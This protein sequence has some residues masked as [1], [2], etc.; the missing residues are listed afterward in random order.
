MLIGIIHL[1][2]PQ[3]YR[4]LFVPY[5]RIRHYDVGYHRTDK[6]GR[7]AAL[8][9]SAYGWH[10]HS[11]RL[12]PCMTEGLLWSSGR[13]LYA[14]NSTL[15]V[16][17]ADVNFWDLE[18]RCFRTPGQSDKRTD[19]NANTGQGYDDT[20]TLPCTFPGSMPFARL[21]DQLVF[22]PELQEL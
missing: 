19:G 18:G 12:S 21:V 17:P 22:L 5:S 2:L 13:G 20:Y 9:S 7:A 11:W 3:L 16:R 8:P 14:P 4:V 15:G 10:A 6:L 1:L